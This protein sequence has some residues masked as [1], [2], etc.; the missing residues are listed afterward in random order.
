MYK[1]TKNDSPLKCPYCSKQFRMTMDRYLSYRRVPLFRFN[2]T[3]CNSCKKSF[4]YRN[5]SAAYAREHN[6]KV[7]VTKEEFLNET[8]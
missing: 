1:R 2:T 7:T 6:M 4:Y 5:I 8:V 3:T